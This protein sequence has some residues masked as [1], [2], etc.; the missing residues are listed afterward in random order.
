MDFKQKINKN[1]KNKS[2]RHS[3][4]LTSTVD[5]IVYLK[6]PEGIT[7]SK[8]NSTQ[9]INEFIKKFEAKGM[10]WSEGMDGEKLL[11]QLT[12]EDMKRDAILR[13]R[14]VLNSIE[15]IQNAEN[16]LK[17][18]PKYKQLLEA[19]ESQQIKARINN[20][21]YQY[22]SINIDKVATT[23]DYLEDSGIAG[24]E[25]N[26]P[27][28]ILLKVY[29]NIL[30]AIPSAPKSTI[31]NKIGITGLDRMT[32]DE[33]KM[34]LSNPEQSL[35]WMELNTSRN[36]LIEELFGTLV[37]E[38]PNDRNNKNKILF[39]QKMAEKYRK[40]SDISLTDKERSTVESLKDLYDLKRE[41]DRRADQVKR[42]EETEKKKAAEDALKKL[43]SEK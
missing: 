29:Q 2:F 13:L 20:Y 6:G 12:T 17:T 9:T 27:F 32:D 3:C 16:E 43:E 42:Q 37:P 25:R 41:R 21:K 30:A 38:N 14:E 19:P 24:I 31:H 23:N 40:D 4:S 35:Q 34:C 36:K 28:L 11:E 39:D 22:P 15:D 18:N 7:E 1:C 33:M 26:A 8:E 10:K 5:R